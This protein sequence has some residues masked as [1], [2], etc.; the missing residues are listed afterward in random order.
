MERQLFPLTTMNVWLQE[1]SV[2]QVLSYLHLLICFSQGRGKILAQRFLA[3]GYNLMPE[4]K[5]SVDGNFTIF[6]MGVHQV[7]F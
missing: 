6:M 5:L 4:L 3:Y 2:R 1:I 7:F